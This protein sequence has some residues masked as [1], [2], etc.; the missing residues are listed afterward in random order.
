[1]R[2]HFESGRSGP[3]RYESGAPTGIGTGLRD[4]DGWLAML[5]VDGLW[6]P[7][8]VGCSHHDGLIQLDRQHQH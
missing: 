5:D 4:T 1:L 6:H 2:D 3:K 8:E 7:A